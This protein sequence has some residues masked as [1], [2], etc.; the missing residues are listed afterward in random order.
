MWLVKVVAIAV[1]LGMD[2]MSVCMAI[3]VRWHGRGQRFRL[4]WH[5][6][7]MQ[8]LMP[9]VG[10]A[11]GSRLTAALAGVERY[12]AAVLVLGVGVKMFYEAVRSHPGAAAEEAEHFVEEHAHLK[13]QDPTRGWSLILLS[14]ATSLDALVVGFSLGLKGESI[15]LASVVIGVTAGV[16]ALVGVALG[17]RLGTALGKRA[18]LAGAGV[19]IVL[20]LAMPWL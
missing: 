16:M 6:G 1:G 5:M 12:I 8:F 7:M 4:A 19:L 9:L 20:G 11:A 10:W 3:G 13:S 17:K 2:A 15:W 18:E 14:V